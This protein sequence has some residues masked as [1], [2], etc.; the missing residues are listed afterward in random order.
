[1]METNL[2]LSIIVMAMGFLLLRNRYL[3]SAVFLIL[4]GFIYATLTGDLNL[5]DVS[6]GLT[7]PELTLFSLDDM[8]YGFIYAGSGQIFLTLTNAVVSTIALVH[9]LFPDR[10]DITPRNLIANMGGMNVTTPFIGGM[11]LCHG[12]GGLAAQY[13]FGAR[14]G[15]AMLI[16]GMIEIVLG[17][18]LSNSIQIIF[19]AFPEFII[20]VMLLLTSLELGRVAFKIKLKEEIPVLLFTALISTILNIAFGFIAGILL[21]LALEKKILNFED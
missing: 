17:L 5:G 1:M 16:E 15:G 9:E 3:P 4:F 6:F 8:I 18:F 19:T 11:P 7:L 14:T 10:R 2:I 20:G 12:A 13:L 21:Y